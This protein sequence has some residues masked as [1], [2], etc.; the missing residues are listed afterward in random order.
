MRKYTNL[1]LD[2]IDQGVLDSD[3]VLREL[4]ANYLSEAEVQNFYTD[5]LSEIVDPFE[6]E[7]DDLD[8]P[9]EQRAWYDTSAEL[10]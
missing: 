5:H 10:M 9:D 6:D 3:F 7:E 2:L 8:G 1:T 4:L